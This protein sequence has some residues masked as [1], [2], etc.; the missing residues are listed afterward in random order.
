MLFRKVYNE[1]DWPNPVVLKITSA[2][3]VKRL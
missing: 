3:A 2:Q 1:L